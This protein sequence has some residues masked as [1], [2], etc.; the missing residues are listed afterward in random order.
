MLF[1]LAVVLIIVVAVS[2]SWYRM[3]RLVE[4]AHA[5]QASEVADNYLLMLHRKYTGLPTKDVDNYFVSN[6]SHNYRQPTLIRL[7]GQFD[8]Q[9]VPRDEFTHSAIDLFQRDPEASKVSRIKEY[10]DHRRFYEYLQ[11]VR[12]RETCLNC[13]QEGLAK[14]RYRK[15]Q[16]VGIIALELPADPTD[17][18]QL[19]NAA[20]V[21]AAVAL[22]TLCAIAAFYLITRWLILAPIEL[23][24]HAAEEVSSGEDTTRVDIRTGDEFEDLGGTFNEM[25][26]HLQQSHRKLETIN[27]SL[28][29]KMGEL[30]ETN[31]ALYEA[32]KVKSEFLANVSHEL[33]TPLNSIIGFAELLQSN[34][35]LKDDAKS[36]RYM[37]NIL[38]SA[39]SLLSII[40]ELLD[41]AK[42]EAGKMELNIEKVVISDLCENLFNLV[43]PIADKK[44]LEIDLAIPDALP[45]METDPGKLQQVLYNLLSNAIKFT[46]EGGRITIRAQSAPPQQ[47]RISVTDTGPG[48]PEDQQEAIFE[49]FR[50]VDGSTSRGHGGAGLGLAIAKELISM[51]G[52]TI[53]VASEPQKGS[54]F[55]ITLPLKAPAKEVQ[56]PLVKL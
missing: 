35:G 19:L 33:R 55:S 5:Q 28:D 40:N 27:K 4:Q 42:I 7:T 49:K 53:A 23:L 36:N 31:V 54:T 52:G 41:L 24:R 1:G 25:L 38:T 47:V 2:V 12:A 11:P 20:T 30:A 48:I 26:D 46:P 44:T 51:L 34:P 13:H 9:T 37:S 8:E 45:L 6:A 10:P 3:Q 16:L 14:Q 43:K 17:Q 21:A 18:Q 22:A 15:G 32:N 39:R 29:A 56:V 50:Q